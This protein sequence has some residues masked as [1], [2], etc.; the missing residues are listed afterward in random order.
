MKINEVELQSGV[1]KKSIR[2]YEEQ[3]LLAPRRNLENGYRDY[4]EEDVK[5]LQR[6]RL[7][8]K[9]GVP[10]EEIRR[11]LHGSHTVGDGMRRHLVTLEREKRNLEESMRL[12]RELQNQEIPISE[13]DAQQVLAQ[14]QAM[15]QTGTSFRTP[16]DVRSR[17]IAPVII[18][19]LVVG[20]MAA[21]SML[22]LWAY[23]LDPENAPPMGLVLVIVGLYM[24]VAVGAVAAL[25]QRIREILKGEQNAAA[26]Y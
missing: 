17:F 22:V 2:Y 24:S 6:I 19:A 12:C 15:E 5:I 21:F 16:Q 10:I 8:R 23:R 3:G 26:E 14:M 1:P 11:M 20:M 25:I 9:L 18:T 13:L 4:D 7:M